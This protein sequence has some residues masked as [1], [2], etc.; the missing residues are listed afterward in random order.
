[1]IR[2][3]LGLS[4]VVL[5]NYFVKMYG[6]LKLL[7]YA[8]GVFLTMDELDVISWSFF[9]LGCDKS[10]YGDLG[11]VQFGLIRFGR[12][13]PDHFT[14]TTIL[15]IY[16]SLQ[17]LDKGKQDFSLSI[18]TRF[19]SNLIVSSA[20]VD[21]FS[22][23]GRLDEFVKF[24]KRL[25]LHACESHGDLKLAKSV[26][27]MANEMDSWFP[28]PYFVLAQTYKMRGMWESF[29]RVR[30]LMNDRGSD[31]PDVVGKSF[32]IGLSVSYDDML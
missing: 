8:F 32:T 6:E 17:A 22:R 25:L 10:G 5:E 19:I 21:M 26:V 24:F 15:A 12:Y 27:E 28:F 14:M 3:G 7:E 2:S 1:M 16:C 4:N 23:C 11:L 29:T 18:A 13:S 30:K 9:I 31:T 20:V